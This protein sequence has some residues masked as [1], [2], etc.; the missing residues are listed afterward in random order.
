MKGTNFVLQLAK[1]SNEYDGIFVDFTGILVWVFI[2]WAY[3]SPGSSV[4]KEHSMQ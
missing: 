2:K 1:Q 3:N 4:K